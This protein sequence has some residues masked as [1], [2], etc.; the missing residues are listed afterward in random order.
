MVL[1]FLS[2]EGSIKKFFVFLIVLLS[3]ENLFSKSAKIFIVNVYSQ[4][5]DVKLGSGDETVIS[6]SG[7]EPYQSTVIKYTQNFGKH[8]LYYKESP[9]NKWNLWKDED[10]QT[11]LCPIEKNKCYCILIGRN[12]E[13]DYFV[14]EEDDLKSPKVSF[15]NASK[16]TVLRMEVSK[17]WNAAVQAYAEKFKPND[18][19]NF[20]SIKKGNYSLFWQFPYQVEDDTYFIQNQMVKTRKFFR[21]KMMSIIFF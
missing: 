20:V 5:M 7:L 21:S 16:R 12:G 8:K 13:V 18:I 11:M 4:P 15:L 17:G 10:G 1:K 14:L 9:E 19:S 6:F 2:L 3:L